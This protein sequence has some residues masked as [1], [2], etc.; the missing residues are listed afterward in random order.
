MALTH[1]ILNGLGWLLVAMAAAGSLYTL[2][3]AVV[4]ARY[5]ANRAAPSRRSE[6][7]TLLKPLHGAEP[8]L[9]ENLSSFLALD[10]DG[11]L[12]LLLGLGRADD[13]ALATIERLRAAYPSARIELIV[14]ATPHGAN[15]KIANLINMTPHAAHPLLV[16]SDSDIAVA[17]DYL[18]RVLAALD[19][20]NV[21]AVTCAYRGRGD[22]GFW[23][24]LGAAGLDWQL[25]PGVLFGVRTGLATPCMGSTIALHAETLAAIGGFPVFADVLADDY[26]IGAAIRARG[27]K[28]AVPP[29]LVAHGCDDASFAALWRHELRWGATILGVAPLG[30]IGQ[31]IAMPLPLALLAAPLLP[32]AAL[33]MVVAALAARLIL[34]TSIGGIAR[35]HPLPLWML[36]LRD[37]LT[38][39]AFLASFFARSVA[40]RDS[41]LVLR[42][43]GLIASGP[44]NSR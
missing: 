42:K 35:S 1:L 16:V 10:H 20:P 44:E 27:L 36:P 21:G 6:A 19:P 40:W 41:G 30:Y 18:S 14:N 4:A 43:D 34:A 37:L 3:A 29:T 5:L 8:R 31:V 13:P 38:F 2:A 23:S 7:V 39:A 33:A 15:G 9:F 26:A 22:A 32:R 12:Q 11:P 28:V 25:L 24:R 17:P